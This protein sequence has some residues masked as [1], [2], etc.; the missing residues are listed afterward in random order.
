MSTEQGPVHL[1]E[2]QTC[3]VAARATER[4][5][6]ALHSAM[7]ILAIKVAL[8]CVGLGS[9]MQLVRKR[10]DRIPT[11]NV[12]QMSAVRAVDRSVALAAAFY[13]GRALCLE[14]SLTLYY[15]LRRQGV[16]VR[17]RMG[18]VTK[19]FSGHAWVE[20]R[21]EPINDVSEHLKPFG[22]LPDQLP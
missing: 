18:I 22:L 2:H 3:A 13:P 9:T 17:F 12:W 5:P 20:Y 4:C 19:P 14:Q 16:P 8:K 10:I 21:G 15:L 6:S 7:V 11:T 1:T